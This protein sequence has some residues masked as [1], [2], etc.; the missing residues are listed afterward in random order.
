MIL[1]EKNLENSN[2]K[3]YL[4]ESTYLEDRY[5]VV[6]GNSETA[7][8]ADTIYEITPC[9]LPVFF[10]KDNTYTGDEVKRYNNILN[11]LY[12]YNLINTEYDFKN[13]KRIIKHANKEDK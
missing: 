12:V 2:K 7:K 8:N 5:A 13:I 3:L 11:A 4:I 10:N 9:I 1:E 6:I